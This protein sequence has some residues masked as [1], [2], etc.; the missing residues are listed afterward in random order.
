MEITGTLDRR[1]AL[2]GADFVL[3]AIGVGGFAAMQ[4]EA[5]L[6]LE[7]GI[8]HAVG[9]TIGPAA[10][11]KS[12]R[13]VPV[14]LAIAR[15]MERLCPDAW[16]INVTN[17]MTTAV[18]AV[19]SCT[20]TRVIGLCD[21]SQAFR[22]LVGDVYGAEPSQVSFDL[23]GVNH[24]AFTNRILVNGRDVTPTL[25]EDAGGSRAP[26]L[27]SWRLGREIFRLMGGW[28]PLVEDRHLSEF[29]PYYVSA[30]D[31]GRARYGEGPLDL[32]DRMRKRD[33]LEQDHAALASGKI[34]PRDLSAYRGEAFHEILAALH[35]GGESTHVV[36]VPN[37]GCCP[38]LASG[39][40]LEV[41]ALLSRG[42]VTPQPVRPGTLAPHVLAILNNLCVIHDYTVQAA[43]TADI[44][45]AR[46]ALL[47]DPFLQNRDA[48]GVIPR[49][50]EG[51]FR[52][53]RPYMVSQS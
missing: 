39:A 12:L 27:E 48:I 32:A 52:I 28:L 16:L 1:D 50:V 4:E 30:T 17:P 26:S 43:V 37:A 19:S 22:R 36:N 46:Q 34:R 35:D 9:D 8:V 14:M 41:P 18:K 11:S 25:Y 10:L 3:T 21:G 24:F 40:V 2:D 13:T 23:V 38:E 51:L 53:N 42:R 44:D 47:L 20:K 7:H 49:L 5:R 45:K 33:K 29:F 31:G 15:D 6:C